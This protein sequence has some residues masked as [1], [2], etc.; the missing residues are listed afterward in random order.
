[1]P[2]IMAFINFILKINIKILLIKYLVM[3]D[4]IKK[5]LFVIDQIN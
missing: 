1:M 5:Y 2:G 3:K 4:Q